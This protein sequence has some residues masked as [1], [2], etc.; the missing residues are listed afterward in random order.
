[1]T[2]TEL[3]TKLRNVLRYDFDAVASSATMTDDEG[4]A[5]LNRSQDEISRKLRVYR[6]DVA[7]SC[8]ASVTEVALNNTGFAKRPFEITQVF[9]SGL[10]IPRTESFPVT[11]K[12]GSPDVW[13]V[14]GETLRFNGYYA[15]I[16]ALTI[17]G[18][19]LDTKFS[20]SLLGAECSLPEMLHPHVAEY[21]A[22]IAV[23]GTATEGSQM[24]RRKSLEDAM[25]S[26]VRQTKNS[27]KVAGL[28]T[29]PEVSKLRY[30]R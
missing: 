9:K 11:Q 12:T 24:V 19:F 17:S 14:E 22:V 10:E 30:A 23:R 1:M 29:L 6:T 21:A 13:W 2:T 25:L 28:P 3:L 16:T 20:S 26:A 27:L 8:P 4:V 5:Y 7:L 18:Y 15:S